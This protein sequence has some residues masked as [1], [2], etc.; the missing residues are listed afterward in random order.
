[1]AVGDTL[2]VCDMHGHAH[3]C[4][5]VKIRDEESVLEIISTEESTTEPPIRISL[6][7]G[8]PKGD[9]LEL[10]VQKAVELGACEIIPFESSRCI[11]RPKADKADKQTERLC[12]IANEASKQCGRARLTPVLSPLSYRDALARAKS[13]GAK[14]LF[15]YEGDSSMSIKRALQGVRTGD[16]LALFVGTEGGFSLDEVAAA[17]E[18]GA[19]TVNLGPRI[20]RCETAPMYALSAISYE[21]ELD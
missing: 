21:L 19:I 17:S 18:L 11:K 1:M 2:T 9:K 15:C 20:L 5:L 10:I 16:S 7:M 3:E 14:I 13:E 8:Y 6:Y 12:R 4:R